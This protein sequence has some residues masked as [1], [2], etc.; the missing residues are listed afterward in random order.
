MTRQFDSDIIDSRDVE[1]TLHDLEWQE[2]ELDD[3]DKQ[4][5]SRLR[6]IKEQASSDPEWKYGLI[7]VSEYYFEDYARELAEDI[8]AIHDDAK[9]PNNFIDWP[10]A[11]EALK[12]DYSVYVFG[13]DT[14]YARS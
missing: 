2:P 3:D 7:F 1:A 5:L 11:A 8:G 9:W 12:E 14:Y 13:L 6:D 4:L 10:A